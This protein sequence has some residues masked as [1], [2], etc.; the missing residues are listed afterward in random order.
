MTLKDFLDTVD[1][2]TRICVKNR[3]GKEVCCGTIGEISYLTARNY[4][5]A[6]IHEIKMVNVRAIP[7]VDVVI[8]RIM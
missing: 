3:S 5:S 6:Y 7:F 8:D 1:A 2:E 4:L